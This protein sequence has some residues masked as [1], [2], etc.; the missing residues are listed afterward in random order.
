MR[1]SLKALVTGFIL[2]DWT[3]F[4]ITVYFGAKEVT[5]IHTG[6]NCGHYVQGGDVFCLIPCWFLLFFLFIPDI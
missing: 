6:V 5:T 1:I 4:S 3:F 2:F